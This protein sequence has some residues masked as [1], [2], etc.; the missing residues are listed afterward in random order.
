MDALDNHSGFGQFRIGL[1]DFRAN[2]PGS[3]FAFDGR[4]MSAAQFGNYAAGYA[5]WYY[6]QSRGLAAVMWAGVGCDFSEDLR[7]REL[8]GGD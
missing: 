5:G 7:T 2:E 1:L 3:T 8:K 4:V 6:G